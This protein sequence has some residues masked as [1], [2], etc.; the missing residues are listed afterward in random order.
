MEALLTHFFES[1]GDFDIDIGSFEITTRIP[2]DEIKT[3]YEKSC[4]KN[5]TG[6]IVFEKYNGETVLVVGCGNSDITDSVGGCSGKHNEH[7]EY[8]I[9]CNAGLC[10][11]IAGLF[12][13]TSFESIPDKSFDFIVFEGAHLCGWKEIKRLAKPGAKL[14][15]Y[16]GTCI[17]Y[18]VDEIDVDA[19]HIPVWVDRCSDDEF[20][21]H[22]YV[23]ALDKK[24]SD[25]HWRDVVNWYKLNFK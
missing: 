21:Y 1:Q 9:D 25:K 15:L 20:I 5:E 17:I 14:I 11:S 3:M 8:T 24:Y 6:Y 10:P 16:D 2:I 18:S 19:C 23:D 12:G 22:V 13:E 7:G 4:T